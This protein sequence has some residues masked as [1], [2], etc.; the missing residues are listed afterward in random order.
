MGVEMI[1]ESRDFFVSFNKADRDWAKWIAYVVEEHGYTVYFQDW[2]FR[3]NFVEHMDRAHRTC[4]RTIAILSDHYFGSAFTLGEWTARYAQDPAAREDRIIPVRHG[5]LT[6]AGLLGVIQYADLRECDEREAERRLLDRIRRATNP[7]F[8]PKPSS[9]PRFPAER[10]A[11]LAKPIFPKDVAHVTGEVTV[12]DA[13]PDTDRR[14]AESIRSR[15]AELNR[16]IEELT[17]DQFRT[18]NQLRFV[19]RVR[20]SGCA[21]SGKTLV[22]TEKAIRLARGGVK[23][24]LLCHNPMLAEHI[25]TLALGTDV[26]VSSFQEWV[27]RFSAYR[28]EGETAWTHYQEPSTR[29]LQVAFDEVVRHGVTYGA[30]I[31]DEA[32]DFREEWWPILEAALADPLQS[33]LYIF[34]DDQQALLPYR[35]IYPVDQPVIDL[36]RNCRNAA[37]IYEILRVFHPQSPEPEM[38]LQRHGTVMVFPFDS[39]EELATAARALNRI[40]RISPKVEIVALTGGPWRLENSPFKELKVPVRLTESWQDSVRRYLFDASTNH[41]LRGEAVAQL[42]G[43]WVRQQLGALSLE[44]H[45][46]SSDVALVSK[47]ARQVHVPIRDRKY[48]REVLKRG[49]LSWTDDA[50]KLKLRWLV[51][52]QEPFSHEPYPIETLEFFRQETWA[53]T[54]PQPRYVQFTRDP[55]LAAADRIYI[56]DV[57]SFK[58]LEVDC[59]IL[60]FSD[61][62][63][64]FTSDLYVALS[65]A[66]SVAALLMRRDKLSLLPSQLRR[67]AETDASQLEFRVK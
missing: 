51:K 32:Q 41:P 49:E 14:F 3:G 47:T 7:N 1:D 66:R 58:G 60:L 29:Q 5:P 57:A 65:R 30:I 56:T 37:E 16:S 9:R 26:D 34:H 2:D 24:L 27:T 20:I 39:G 48:A 19:N 13:S 67:A 55:A 22:A 42:T 8:R 38:R 28:L 50:G 35:A 6:D 46:H 11:L 43:P 62:T 53:D 12:E 31:V 10:T 52:R 17:T 25:R 64:T 33:I 4:R 44:P 54:L 36:S 63:T 45:P 40:A 15:M 61:Y 23:T 18:I 21:G 59:A